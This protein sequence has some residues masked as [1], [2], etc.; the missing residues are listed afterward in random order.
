MFE[1]FEDLNQRR[2]KS[3]GADLTSSGSM[4]DKEMNTDPEGWFQIFNGLN[5]SN[6]PECIEE[7]TSI[8]KLPIT[9]LDNNDIH[10]LSETVSNDL[11]LYKTSSNNNAIYDHLFKPTHGFAKK[12]IPEWN[13]QFTSNIN[14]LEDSKL[15]LKEAN[16]LRQQLS[17]QKY[18]I[19]YDNIME[20]W[21]HTKKNKDFL[22]KYSYIEWDYLKQFNK[23]STFL[24][25]L[26]FIQIMSPLM[27]LF[28]PILMLLFPFLILKAQGES[29][30]FDLYIDVLKTIGKNHFIG[31]ALIN[32]DSLSADKVIYLIFT[33]GLYLLQV[34]Q[35][36]TQCN[37]FYKNIK[38]INQYLINIKDYVY[39][40]IQSMETFIEI[41]RNKKTFHP[42]LLETN[43]HLGKLKEFYSEIIN[44]QPFEHSMSK[45]SEFGNLLKCFYE[46]HSNKEYEEALQYSFGFEGYINNL[47]GV[48]ENIEA[49]IISFAN[50]TPLH[51]EVENSSN[52]KIEKQ[53]Y[54]P[55]LDDPN[56]VK[57]SCSFDKNMI[58]SAPNA[59]GKTTFI[60]TTAINII[61]SQ[62]VGC[63]FYKTCTLKPYT[64]IHSYL[65]IPDT[66][67]RDSLFQAESRR[68]KEIINIIHQHKPN[69]S[70]HFCIFDELYSGTN[71][72][73]A[74]KSAYAFLLYLSKFSNVNFILTTHYVTICKKFNKS[75]CIQNYKMDVK[76]LDNG[77]LEYTYK[78]KKGISKIQGAITILKQM[79]Y[80]EEIIQTIR[81]F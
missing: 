53:Y 10:K 71:P 20:I 64:H 59:G 29:I 32:M 30:T 39:Y 60:K 17:I 41:H 22:I 61:F 46:L 70:R 36:L 78:L 12:L 35:N 27:S 8:F 77:K 34:Y 40:S 49:G 7:F 2:I 1:I 69:E 52:C 26:S 9:Y 57:N 66:S 51:S 31:K 58:I 14:F 79:E 72:I 5:T 15:V 42:F 25:Y 21:D 3:V 80:P 4:T 75:E 38:C 19:D 23:S 50:F 24:Q 44:I 13:K 18:S 11:E 81:N 28:F 54:P 47:L 48:Y 62:Q 37:H 73:E 67:E 68:C 65:N 16:L 74:T 6:R 33:L 43:K 76:E 55:L 56:V 63:G 45:F